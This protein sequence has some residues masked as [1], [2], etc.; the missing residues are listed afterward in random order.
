VLA[1]QQ[2]LTTV[3]GEIEELQATASHL[4]EQAAMSTLTLFVS[5][6]PAPVIAQ[7]EAAFDPG[8][9]AESATA[10]LVGILQGLATAGIWFGIVWLPVLIGLGIASGVGVIMA[11][12]VL[13][14]INAGVDVLPDAS[15]GPA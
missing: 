1:V 6:K 14:R 8:S 11:R 12:W 3:R 7:Q 4:R 5:L 13:R 2:E 15:G 9:E 10:R